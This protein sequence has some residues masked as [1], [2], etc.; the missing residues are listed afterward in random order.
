LAGF[1]CSAALFIRG[2][3]YHG[4]AGGSQ[5][6]G[7]DPHA[8]AKLEHLA[9]ATTTATIAPSFDGE[10]RVVEARQEPSVHVQ[11]VPEDKNHTMAQLYQR[12]AE[13][14]PTSTFRPY[15]ET[16]TTPWPSYIRG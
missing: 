7:I 1:Q 2:A 5:V 15:L 4:A 3:T 10:A 6:V 14:A 9:A 16:R 12:L 13:G 8:A 11:A